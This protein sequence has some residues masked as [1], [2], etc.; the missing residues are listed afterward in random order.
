M[1]L[2]N[3]YLVGILFLLT[4]I[5]SAKVYNVTDFGA[6]NDGKSINTVSIQKAI[7]QCTKDGGGTVLLS[8]GGK[9]MTGTIYLKDNVTLHND[10]GTT[11]LG[12][13]KL[14]GAVY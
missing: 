7:D 13:R 1:N 2:K 10:N 8:G 9:F 5:L 6:V 12:N 4:Q 3:F 14:H 11:L